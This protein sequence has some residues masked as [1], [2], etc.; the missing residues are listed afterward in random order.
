MPSVSGR[1]LRKP[2]LPMPHSADTPATLVYCGPRPIL[3][4]LGLILSLML[5]GCASLGWSPFGRDAPPAPTASTRALKWGEAPGADLAAPAPDAAYRIGPE[6]GLEIAVWRDDTLKSTVLVRPDGGI[7]FPLA[8]DMVVAGMTAAEVQTALTK[9]LERFLPDPVLTVT[10]LRV[11]SYRVYVLGRVNRPGDY[12]LGRRV[13]VLQA[14][15]LAGGLTPFAVEDEIRII[16]RAN[17]RN[18]ALPFQ[19]SRIRKGADLSQNIT[20]QSGDVVFVP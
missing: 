17:G 8:G 5:S 19:Y 7:T 3:Q 10:V 13:D 20:L 1:H 14:L 2:Q 16:R 12:A 4:L 15:S 6:D 18:V 11:A 9:R